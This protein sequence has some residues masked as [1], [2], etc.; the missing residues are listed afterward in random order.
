MTTLNADDVRKKKKKL[1][2]S[3]IAVE[4]ESNTATPE[5]SLAVSAKN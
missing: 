1:T 5:N 3:T 4:T 2:H